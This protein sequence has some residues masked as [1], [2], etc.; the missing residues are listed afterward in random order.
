MKNGVLVLHDIL[1]DTGAHRSNLEL[2]FTYTHDTTPTLS[3]R[4]AYTQLQYMYNLAA[5]F[6]LSTNFYYSVN[7]GRLNLPHL[8]NN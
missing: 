7:T 3:H 2:L 8:P 4:S 5:D 6:V 1:A